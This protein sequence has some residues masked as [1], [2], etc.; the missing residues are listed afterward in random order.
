MTTVNSTVEIFVRLLDEGTECRRP[1]RGV[2]VGGG[3]FRLLP[4]SSY[5]PDDEHW[6]FPPGTIVRVKEIRS[7]DS[8]YLLAVTQE[9]F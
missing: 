2:S 3:L 8:V 9:V 6:E 7:A 4:T 1:T 5:D